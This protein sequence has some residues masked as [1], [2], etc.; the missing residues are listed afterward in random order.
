[1][2]KCAQCGKDTHFWKRVYGHIDYGIRLV[3][4]FASIPPSSGDMEFC[5]KLCFNARKTV[6]DPLL[7]SGWQK[8]EAEA[9]DKKEEEERK[10]RQEDER[11]WQE[12]QTRI[13]KSTKQ[14]VKAIKA[15]P[16]DPI[17]YLKLAD[18]F[19]NEAGRFPDGWSGGFE[20]IDKWLPVKWYLTKKELSERPSKKFD[21]PIVQAS[22]STKN[23]LKE[24]GENY[25]K[26]I[27]LGIRDVYLSACAKLTYAKILCLLVRDNECQYYAREAEKD[28]RKYLRSYPE[29]LSALVKLIGCIWMY[30]DN[31]KIHEERTSSMQARIKEAATRQKLGAKVVSSATLPGDSEGPYPENWR[32]LS[33]QVRKRDGY[34][35]TQ[36]GAKDV[37]LHV[38]HIVPLSLG[39]SNED[40][41]LTTLCDYCHGEIHPRMGKGKS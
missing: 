10:K 19:C 32:E 5:D 33:D 30:E 24:A 13:G 14:L 1:M 6:L 18:L 9:R 7:L 17:T 41:N 31:Q 34:R 2:G 22:Y 8:S 38:H 15:N 27:S 40:N 36:C 39:G 23:L 3:E 20:L 35:C 37:E 25:L 11:N 26:A 4:N 21:R 12:T 28:L 29:D 16:K